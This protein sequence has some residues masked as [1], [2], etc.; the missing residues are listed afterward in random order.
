MWFSQKH[1]YRGQDP[2]CIIKS[3]SALS[4]VSRCRRPLL[5]RPKHLMWLAEKA[6]QR[7]K[8]YWLSASTSP[9]YHVVSCWQES[10]Y[11]PSEDACQLPLDW[12]VKQGCVFWLQACLESFLLF[13]TMHPMHRRSQGAQGT[14]PP[15]KFSANL[16]ILWLEKRCPKQKVARLK[17]NSL[18]P[19]KYFGSS[20]NFGLATPLIPWWWQRCH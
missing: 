6:I 11:I 2:L 4:N 8:K 9:P 16:V 19:Q 18:A 13:V 15:P 12:K 17:A 3:R 14:M 5:N 20:K 7:S 1:I 10:I